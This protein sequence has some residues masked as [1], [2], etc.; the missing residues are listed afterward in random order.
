MNSAATVALLGQEARDDTSTIDA[1]PTNVVLSDL[2]MI[3]RNSAL[4][5]IFSFPQGIQSGYV[6]NLLDR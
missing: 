2:A 4:V 6:R 5:V 1:A 3:L